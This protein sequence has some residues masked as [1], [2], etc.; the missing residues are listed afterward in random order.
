MERL[1]RECL[2]RD[3]GKVFECHGHVTAEDVVKRLRVSPRLFHV[4]HCELDVGRD[5]KTMALV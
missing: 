2:S 1:L 5:P 4:V 3:L